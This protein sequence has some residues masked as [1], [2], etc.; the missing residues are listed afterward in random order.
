MEAHFAKK[1]LEKTNATSLARSTCAVC[2]E[3]KHTTNTKFRP[4]LLATHELSYLREEGEW[5]AA[6]ND[7]FTYDPPFNVLNGLP[8][9]PSTFVASDPNNA[10]VPVCNDCFTSVE[11]GVVP[12]RSIANKNWVGPQSVQM[13]S[14]NTPTKLLTCP[15]RSK[16]YVSKLT[17]IGQRKNRQCAV[18]HCTIAF[19]Q[20]NPISQSLL[21]APLTTLPSCFNVTF[22][23]NA[24]PT[25]KQLQ[26][27]F[28]IKKAEVLELLDQWHRNG[29]P[30]FQSG[31]WDYSALAD[32][33]LAEQT[34]V[35]DLLRSLGCVD[36]I[37]DEADQV[38]EANQQQY[39]PGNTTVKF[40][41]PQQLHCCPVLYSRRT[42]SGG[43]S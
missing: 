32:I 29:H 23:G 15:I 5:A 28:G 13:K 40:L 36:D 8:L 30:A 27:K 12:A 24:K 43:C 14:A 2:W 25:Q 20:T 31:S 19:P 16:I 6:A 10:Q 4:L 18:R 34:P 26:K 3:R 38:A 41:K 17:K 11:K 9:L 35:E 42:R 33:E 22:V 7:S 37:D 21:P 39:V 1:Y